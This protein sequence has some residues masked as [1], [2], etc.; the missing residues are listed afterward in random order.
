MPRMTGYVALGSNLGDRS[1]HLRLAIERMVAAGVAPRALSSV[2]ETEAVDCDEPL[3]FLNM[4]LAVETELEPLALLDALQAIE[5]RAGRAAGTTRAPRTLDIDVLL[6]DDLVLDHPRL[7]LPHPRMW[8]RSFV[9]APLAEVA[10]ELRNP[11][12]GRTVAEERSALARPSAVRRLG[13]LA[14]ARAV[15]L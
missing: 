15:P 11:A 9:L 6:L 14:R 1:A 3:P 2:W 4:A 7:T 8:R 13:P 10:P 5:R 12:S